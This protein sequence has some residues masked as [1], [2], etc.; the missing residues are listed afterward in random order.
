ME[1]EAWA[2][3]QHHRHF[4]AS[5]IIVALRGPG[6]DSDS[7]TLRPEHIDANATDQVTRW[8]DYRAAAPAQISGQ[9]VLLLT[10]FVAQ[11]GIVCLAAD[12]PTLTAPPHLEAL[13]LSLPLFS[14]CRT[15]AVR[16]T[17]LPEYEIRKYPPQ[18]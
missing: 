15:L 16:F 12:S 11:A 3:Y 4:D 9:P 18:R 7:V 5:E 13:S 17:Y 8:D 14:F 1:K 10:N 6:A 2:A